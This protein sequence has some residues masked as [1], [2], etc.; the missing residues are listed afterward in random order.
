MATE[1][2]S[3]IA[4]DEPL[5]REKL[6]IL[7]ASET[8]IRVV[9][10]C[11]DG[12]QTQAALRDYRPDLLLIDINMPVVDGF[13]VMKSIPRDQMPI[14]IFT[15]AYDQYAI[16]AFEERAF[17]YLLKPFDQQRLH[18]AIQRTRAELL[19]VHHGE[20]AR[21]MLDLFARRGTI[22]QP[23]KLI[24]KAGGRVVFLDADEVDWIEAASNY[25][26]VHADK[27]SYL[28]RESIGAF[29]GRLDLA[30]F[31]RIHR[32]AIA[33]ISK[34]KELHPCNTGEYIL[35][36][37]NGK[38]LSCSRG[39]RTGLQ[40][41]MNRRTDRNIQIKDIHRKSLPSQGRTPTEW[42]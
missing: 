6:R 35:V 13:Q 29:S 33:N 26:K 34:I 11:R 3:I 9:A 38:Q 18:H 12:R 19:R 5:A 15:T 40:Q 30:Q 4:D 39:Y 28:V 32:S 20:F 2:R 31:V 10:E 7:L 24:I 25:V 36:L 27:E 8:G 17:D 42:P 37:K 23:N 41:L 16:R 1:I 21:Q 22:P 14:V